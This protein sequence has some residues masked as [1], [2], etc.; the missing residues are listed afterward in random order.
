MS[1]VTESRT[2]AALVW[3]SLD[4][5]GWMDAVAS[6][7]LWGQIIGKTRLALCP[8][9]NH[10]WNVTLYLS[11]RGLTTSPMPANGGVLDVE[12]DLVD[13]QLVLRNS[14][15]ATE[16]MPL[17]AG[18]LSR[19]YR[20]YMD[21]LARLGVQLSLYPFSV[22]MP[23][24]V[25][26]D[27]DPRVCQYDRDW[28]NRFFHALVQADRLLK[29]FRGRFAGKGSPVHFF[30]G[31]FDLAT[32]RFSGRPAPQYPGGIP[33]VGN[34]VMQEAYSQEVSSAGFWPGDARFPEAAFYSY[35]YPE[36]AGYKDAAI[37][38]TAARYEP[39]LGEFLLPYRAIRELRDPGAAVLDFLESSYAAA[40]DLAGWDRRA[41]ERP[42][43][44]TP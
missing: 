11:A 14:D 36:P 29:Q 31:A 2:N 42:A 26:L 43:E 8:M 20:D 9:L 40:A 22:E 13:H 41:L 32:T 3:P 16:T 6:L 24:R 39:A 27:Q 33:N 25:R 30:W 44:A 1:R 34:W 35:A 38:P 37:R 28:A 4:E 19:F 18:P 10:W 15:G 17:G 5:P 12:L 7:T 23:E 21:R